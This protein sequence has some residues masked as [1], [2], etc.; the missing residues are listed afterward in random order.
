MI[1][2][3]QESSARKAH[4]LFVDDEESLTEL[5]KLRLEGLGY[6]VSVF[7]QSPLALAAFQNNPQQFDA[8][9]TDLT[10]PELNGLQLAS[11]AHE[12]R[13]ELPIVLCT[14]DCSA[15]SDAEIKACG[16]QEVILKPVLKKDWA[17]LLARVIG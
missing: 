2:P 9:I 3:L 6:A 8:V 11:I 4:I 16:I 13:P 1:A 12:I 7:T 14:G 17:L 15:Y 10:M 5:C